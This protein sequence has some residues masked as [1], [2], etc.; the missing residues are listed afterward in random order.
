M[1]VIVDL[2]IFYRRPDS[3]KNIMSDLQDYIFKG[4]PFAA[5]T[6]DRYRASCLW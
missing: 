4:L 2:F 6:L 5:L 3:T 1:S